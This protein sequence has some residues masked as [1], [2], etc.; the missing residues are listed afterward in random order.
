M[1]T[2]LKNIGTCNKIP[3]TQGSKML[4]NIILDKGTLKRCGDILMAGDGLGLI[5]YCGLL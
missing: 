4:N 2:T 1:L 5:L 3:E